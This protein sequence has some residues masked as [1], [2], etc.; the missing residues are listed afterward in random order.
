MSKCRKS[1]PPDRRRRWVRRS[2]SGAAAVEFALV[3]LPLVFILYGLIA[4]GM[5]FALKQSMTN[6]A[7]D[8]ARS[9]IGATDPVATAKATVAQRLDWL[10]GKYNPATDIT[11]PAPTACPGDPSHQ[12]ITVTIN[13]PYDARPLVPHAPGLG[14]ITPDRFQSQATVQIS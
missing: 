12:C 13:Y 1:L 5:M 3:I 7:S 4:F 10:G 2:E 11:V 14:L 6:A 8:A 9:A